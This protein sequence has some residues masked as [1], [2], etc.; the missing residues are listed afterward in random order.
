MNANCLIGWC[1][2]VPNSSDR[3]L[4]P[5]SLGLTLELRMTHCQALR[6]GGH[7]MKSRVLWLTFQLAMPGIVK[8][9]GRARLKKA[10]PPYLS[11]DR[12]AW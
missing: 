2:V 6:T 12:P 10:A 8:R 9:A 5:F 4:P 7:L 11:G 3:S 1:A